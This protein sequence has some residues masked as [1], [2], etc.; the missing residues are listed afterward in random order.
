[1]RN[2]SYPDF[3]LT[4]LEP[5]IGTVSDPAQQDA[6]WGAAETKFAGRS[7]LVAEILMNRASLWEQKQATAKAGNFYLEIV[8]RYCNA[9]PFVIPAL[10]K[11]EELLG[12]QKTKVLQLYGQSWAKI[13]KPEDMAGPFMEQSNWFRVGTMYGEK[14]EAAGQTGAAQRVYAMLGVKQG[15]GGK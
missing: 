6:M 9:G 8:D 1:M 5:M 2:Q 11:A 7:D 3:A 15:T 4:V 14:L 13:Q 12:D 10:A